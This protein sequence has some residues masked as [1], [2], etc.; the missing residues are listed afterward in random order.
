M[1]TEPPEDLQE[2][3]VSGGASSLQMAQAH[4]NAHLASI[5]SLDGK[6]MFIIGL[7]SVVLSTFV[8]LTA[9]SDLPLGIVIV[10]LLFASAV[11]V[12]GMFALWP[13]EIDQFP[14]PNDL[15]T[16]EDE[17][18]SDDLL[19]WTYV[20]TLGKASE[21]ASSV[22]STKAK[23][24]LWMLAGTVTHMGAIVGSVVAASG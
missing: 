17:G 7:N 20:S 22:V 15:L 14:D 6:V 5:D 8:T 24:A 2:H 13:R 1:T 12:L 18:W 9:A 19:A 10:P 23:A 4:L 3:T 11:V 16:Y 21:Q